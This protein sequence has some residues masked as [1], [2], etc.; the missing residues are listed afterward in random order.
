MMEPQKL[1]CEELFVQPKATPALSHALF[2]FVASYN[3]PNMT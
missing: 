2:D 1:T 3:Q